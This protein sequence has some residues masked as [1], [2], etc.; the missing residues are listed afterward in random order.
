[1]GMGFLDHML[2]ESHLVA[3]FE[4]LTSDPKRLRREPG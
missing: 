3:M 2:E 1:M 4:G